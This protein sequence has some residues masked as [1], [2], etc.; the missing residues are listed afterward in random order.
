MRTRAT[1]AAPGGTGSV[2]AAIVW[3]EGRSTMNPTSS[4]IRRRPARLAPAL[5]LALAA[6]LGTSQLALAATPTVQAGLSISPTSAP[7]GATITVV[8]TARNITNRSLQASAG[9]DVPSP[10]HANYVSGTLGCHPRNIGHLVYCGVQN[11]APGATVTIT[12]HVVPTTAGT[13]NFRAY[14]RETYVANDT[15]AYGTLT[16]H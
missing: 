1:V 5:V 9:I 16:I 7:A 10:L 15:F 8:A 3:Q 2:P 14:A 6:I 4:L 12:I 13:Y 11:L